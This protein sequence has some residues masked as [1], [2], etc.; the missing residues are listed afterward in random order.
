[1]NFSSERSIPLS[2][3]QRIRQTETDRT[4][5]TPEQKP[6]STPPLTHTPL[7]TQAWGN[8]P[9]LWLR[10]RPSQQEP[11]QRTSDPTR[12][13]ENNTGLP[14]SLKA[15]I[16]HLSGIS[17]DDVHV[18]YNSADPAQVQAL[19]YTQGTEIHVGPGQEEHLAHE[20]WHVVQQKQGRVQP[21]LQARGKLINHEEELEKEADVMAV[22]ALHPLEDTPAS[23][24][25]VP[26]RTPTS[27]RVIQRNIGRHG[28]IGD[29]VLQGP[30]GN[31]QAFGTIVRRFIQNHRRYY[32]V[33][34]PDNTIVAG[35]IAENDN[36]YALAAAQG[37]PRHQIQMQGQDNYLQ[38]GNWR[39]WENVHVSSHNPQH[40]HVV[41]NGLV[42]PQGIQNPSASIIRIRYRPNQQRQGA[43][44]SIGGNPSPQNTVIEERLRYLHE[45]TS[46]ANVNDER[47]RMERYAETLASYAIQLGIL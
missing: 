24:K 28:R 20:A 7:Y 8:H 3:V 40:L 17:M 27:H 13:N 33:M 21:T 25:A 36:Y 30:Q 29:R 2:E 31:R 38:I 18:H 26:V 23:E 11:L 5:T 46:Q 34:R 12:Q 9:P 32:N 44:A 14:N 10:L 35:A 16:E 19:A 22:R 6:S 47:D 45:D 15:G 37:Q 42:Q 41:F 1:M 43:D 39:Y 4:Q